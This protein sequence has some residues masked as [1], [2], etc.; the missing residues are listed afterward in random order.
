MPFCGLKALPLLLVLG[1][2]ACTE[3]SSVAP[4]PAPADSDSATP[5]GAEKDAA[6]ASG[7]EPA[8]PI[9]TEPLV[10]SPIRIT[11]A[12]L[13]QPFASQ[14]ARKPPQVIDIPSNPRLQVPAGFTVNVFA[15]NLDR[16][17]W[18]ALTPEGDVLVTETRQNRIRRLQD[19]NDDGAA[20]AVTT[21]A[22]A[23]HGLDIPFGMA[24]T[25]DHFYL[26][27]TST[28]RRYPYRTGQATLQGS[29][30]VIAEL[31]GG[32][33]RQHWTRNVVVSPDQQRLYVSIGSRSNV[34]AEPLPRASVQVM[35]LD[36]SA[37]ETVASG[38]RNPVGLDFHPVTGDLYTTVNERDGL[39]DDLVPDYLTRIQAG[40]FYG[41][42]YAYLQPDWLDPR[43]VVDGRSRRPDLAAQ[44]Q[45]PD[46]LFQA[47]SA[48]LGLQFYDGNTFPQRY[49][50]GAFVAFRGSW[51]RQQGTGYKLVF[52]PFSSE[53]RPLGHY[54]D[55][56]TGFLVDPQGPT[57]WGRP[58]G[59]LMMPDGSLL[60]TEE[61]NGR[62][63]RVQFS[64]G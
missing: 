1:L 33:Y 5:S 23:S 51:N 54:E 37:P 22:D 6:I 4:S 17:R 29:G 28:L 46:V 9:A 12:D 31:P 44:T 2:F 60:F 63:Y 38:L 14:S 25:A 26:G 13:P 34:S 47:H 24:F 7:A 48:A 61:M 64:Q 43:Q 10:P 39:G 3:P 55:F 57:T 8:N 50:Q 35:A 16:P 41:W 59:L 36:G 49:H 40:E 58:V 52:V 56:L 15:E 53:G 30:E 11:L 19:Q 32:G 45:T 20:D 42:P 27:N 21:F 62:I 18:L